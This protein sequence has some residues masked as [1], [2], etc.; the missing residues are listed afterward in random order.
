M[1]VFCVVVAMLALVVLAPGEALAG[2]T[3]VTDDAAAS[4]GGLECKRGSVR[5]DG[6]TLT[7]ECRGVF[8]DSGISIGIGD[9]TSVRWE[10][11]MRKGRLYAEQANGDAIWIE[12][13]KRELDML[14][15]A[16]TKRVTVE[17]EE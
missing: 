7:L 1:R 13:P 15:A 11:G 14:Q 17:E 8:R 12:L 16:M 5:L 9:L 4:I 3:F 10:S 2:A 6:T